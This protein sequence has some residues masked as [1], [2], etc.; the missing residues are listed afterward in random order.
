[1]S[2]ACGLLAS[3]TPAVALVSGRDDHGL[4]ERPAIG[5][6]K[7]PSDLTVVA[8][9]HDGEF[10][11]VLG[12]E[13]LYAYVRLIASGD[14]GWIADHDLR[15]EAVRVDPPPPRRVLFVAAAQRDGTPWIKVR[16]TTDG[17]EE[18]VP[19][20]SLREVGAR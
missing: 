13:G 5:L 3:G 12:R 14:E 16:Y 2:G 20:S 9:A 6:S 1:M 4:L 17:A 19:A 10:A 15:G 8:T 11:T 18:W 7:T